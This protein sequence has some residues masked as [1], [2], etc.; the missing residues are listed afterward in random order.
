MI[1]TAIEARPADMTITMH[2]C[3][4]NFRSSWIAQG[5]YEPVAEILFNQIGVDAYFMEFDTERAGGFEPLRLV[6]KNKTVVLGLVTSKSG[7]LESAEE[8]ERRI[9]SAARFVGMDQ[10]CLSPQC[11]FASTEEGNVLSEEEQ[12]AKLARIVEV[13]G[14]VWGG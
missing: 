11:G 5:G 7:A 9:D 1:N 6:P 2:L 4:G 14:K 13:A 12:W 3:R 8:L 10:L